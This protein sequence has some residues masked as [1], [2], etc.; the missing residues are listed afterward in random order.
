MKKSKVIVL[1][2]TMILLIIFPLTVNAE[3]IT[4]SSTQGI[5]GTVENPN[6]FQI[7]PDDYESSGPNATDVKDMYKF[8]GSIAGVIQI[9]GT[10]VSVGVMM[11]L[12]IRYMLASA[13]EK[14]EYRERMLPYFIGAILL[15]G[16]SNIVKV[17]FNLFN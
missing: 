15:F 10:I 5:S 7:N 1:I 14:A 8:G 6:D 2:L 3:I 12:G 16:A 9:V 11:I 17:V 4:S 13:D